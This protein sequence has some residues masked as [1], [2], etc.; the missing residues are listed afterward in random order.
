MEQVRDGNQYVLRLE[1]GEEL[2]AAL[3][4]LAEREGI[5]GGYF[6]AFG[7][8][9]R[10]RLQYFDPERRAYRDNEVDRQVEVVSLM[11]N[12]ARKD[13]RPKL[14][15]HG[16]FGDREARTC[17]GHVAE[18]VVNP[19]LEVFLTRLDVE[20][21]RE[22]DPATG[23]DLLALG[24]AAEDEEEEEPTAEEIRTGAASFPYTP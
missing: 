4:E 21:R 17:S 8:F 20:L 22:K 15:I 2:V 7:A 24:P 3:R 19:T 13:G 14:H 9:S 11:G 23:L 18:G 10:V 6:V 1:P 5:R 16:A 12:I